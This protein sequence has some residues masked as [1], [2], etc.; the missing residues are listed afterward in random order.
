MTEAAHVHSRTQEDTH[1]NYSE[2]PRPTS[3]D[4][5]RFNRLAFSHKNP[6]HIVSATCPQPPRR[7]D[8]WLNP[9]WFQGCA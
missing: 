8:C 9:W 7:V 4:T 6:S 3:R 1:T 5:V 2:V